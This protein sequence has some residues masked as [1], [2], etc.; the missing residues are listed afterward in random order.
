MLLELVCHTGNLI[1]MDQEGM[2]EVDKQRVFT[3]VPSRYTRDL[4]GL[5][6]AVVL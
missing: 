1:K 5:V 6:A 4:V 2:L 3:S